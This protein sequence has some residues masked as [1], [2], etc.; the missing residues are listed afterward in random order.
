M[1]VAARPGHFEGGAEAA[2]GS[3]WELFGERHETNPKLLLGQDEAEM[4]RL[5]RMTRGGD[6]GQGPMPEAGGVMDQ[7]A[8]MLDAFAV[9]SAAEAELTRERER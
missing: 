6:F 5:W 9:M 1:A 4:V 8:I 2:D 7:A 3:A